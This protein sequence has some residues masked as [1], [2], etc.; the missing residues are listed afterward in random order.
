MGA[1]RITALVGVVSRPG[2][3]PVLEKDSLHAVDGRGF[4]DQR[5]TGRHDVRGIAQGRDTPCGRAEQ[6]LGLNRGDGQKDM[7]GLNRPA[8]VEAR[9]PL[10][11]IAAQCI[12]PTLA[13][14]INGQLFEAIPYPTIEPA[15][16][17]Q[18]LAFVGR[19]RKQPGSVGLFGNVDRW[20]PV[21]K[22]PGLEI[23]LD[24][25]AKEIRAGREILRAVV[26]PRR[27]RVNVGTTRGTA[28]ARPRGLVDHRDLVAGGGEILGRRQA[29]HA[30]TDDENVRHATPWLES[31]AQTGMMKQILDPVRE[32]AVSCLV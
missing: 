25:A 6:R 32:T 23:S 19:G 4:D 9:G 18:T 24:T 10:S 11:G 5:M 22:P 31:G 8:L 12:D 7:R 27:G 28:P 2:Q 17:D 21:R 13:L 16:A 30:G 3:G 15:R 1:A 14:D 20:L 29:G 26:K